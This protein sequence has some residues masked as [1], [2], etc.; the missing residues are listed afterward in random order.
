LAVVALADCV[1]G[2]SGEL[3]KATGDSRGLLLWSVGYAVVQVCGLVVGAQLA[4]IEGAAAGT[5]LAALAVLP[6]SFV[7][8]G[9][10]LAA[11][12]L[13]LAGAVLPEAVLP[14]VAAVTGILA[15]SYLP[16]AAAVAVCGVLLAGL[17]VLG[18]TGLRRHRRQLAAVRPA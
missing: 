6:I 10:R 5:A 4:G 15:G 8:S 12:P 13:R 18:L 9:R 11:P 14:A 1:F 7:Q 16:D 17:C 3:L 2:T